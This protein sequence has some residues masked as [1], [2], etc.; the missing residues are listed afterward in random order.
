MKRLIFVFPL[1]LLCL[2]T[3][4]SY[5]QKAFFDHYEEG[6][7]AAK[8]EN[9]TAVVQHMSAA[10][11][12]EPKEN[13]KAR[14][15]G[16]V[17][18]PYHPYYYRGVAY[19]NLGEFEKAA[20]DLAKAKGVGRVALGS[21]E[22]FQMKAEAKLAQAAQPAQQPAPAQQPPAQ[23]PGLP[24]VPTATVDP[25]LA[26]ARQRAQQAIGAAQTAMK[27]AQGRNAQTLASIQFQS[28]Q[29]LLLDARQKS[30]DAETAADFE[31]AAQV[32]ERAKNTFDIAVDAAQ[33]A[34]ANQRAAP[35]RAV[36]ETLSPVK[37]RVR[38]A[39]GEYFSGNYTRAARAL[40][41][42]TKA[43]LS[44]SHMAHVFLGASYY[45]SYVLSG[46]K[47]STYL[48]QA[49]NAFKRAKALNSKVTLSTR[50]FSPRVRTYFQTAVR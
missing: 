27:Q 48:K 19:F 5:A 1:M 20:A 46:R 41:D 29:D 33:M 38:R 30:V 17:F 8:A 6:L 16:T 23:Q 34:A 11:A 36:E 47:N 2:L 39:L 31:R 22:S 32:A 3:T 42:L 15:V 35:G 12:K 37:D 43:E 10:I 13:P 7:K 50:Y 25:N 9:W 44:R 45:N 4:E 14:A 49:N 21:V 40:E 18:F 26:P 24:S 28:A